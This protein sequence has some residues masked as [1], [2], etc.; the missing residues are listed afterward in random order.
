VAS[1]RVCG[2]RQVLQLGPSGSPFGVCGDDC[3]SDGTGIDSGLN[4][5]LVAPNLRLGVG[6]SLLGPA[7]HAIGSAV[8]TL[9]CHQ[10]AN[11][12]VDVPRREQAPIQSFSGASR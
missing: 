10:L 3:I 1:I 9:A 5:G 12:S 2:D 7:P 8:D 4:C 6:K 11:R